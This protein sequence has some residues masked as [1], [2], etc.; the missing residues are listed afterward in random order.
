MSAFTLRLIACVAML[1]DHIGYSYGIL[2]FR[3]IGRLAFP[4]FLFLIYNGYQH[5]SSKWR[6]AFRLAFFA[7]LSQIPFSLFGHNTFLDSNGNVF[8]TLLICLICFWTGDLM[9]GNKVLKWFCLI[10]WIMAF[11]MYYLGLIRSDYGA[12]AVLMALSIFLFYGEALWKRVLLVVSTSCSVFYSFLLSCVIALK[13][14]IVGDP[15]MLSIPNQWAI[16]QAFSLLAFIFIFAYNGQKGGVSNS[17]LGA[18]I[19]QYGFYLFYPAHM[20][21]LW[22]IRMLFA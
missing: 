2:S 6:Y 20:L 1:I 7:I 8:F 10:P 16:L 13:D 12:K 14:L 11:G 21:I 15:V 22:L 17:K 3:I 19:V 18:K 4:I 5:T 9:R